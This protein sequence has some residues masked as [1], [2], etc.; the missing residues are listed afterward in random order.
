MTQY[1]PWLVSRVYHGK[2]IP[3]G[4][5]LSFWSLRTP[6]GSMGITI[7]LIHG[8]KHLVSNLWWH[9]FSKTKAKVTC[10]NGP[11]SVFVKTSRTFT[12]RLLKA[13][14]MSYC[15]AQVIK[16]IFFRLFWMWKS[17][18]IITVPWNASTARGLAKMQLLEYYF[19]LS[20]SVDK[21]WPLETRWKG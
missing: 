12:W 6:V 1:S 4:C 17:T 8:V 3:R 21:A 20:F 14:P 5:N 15:G 19:F 10:R 18:K 7:R 11:L 16:M 2:I 13:L 9:L